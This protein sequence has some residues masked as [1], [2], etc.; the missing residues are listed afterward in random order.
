MVVQNRER[1]VFDQRLLEYTLLERSVCSD[2]AEA[3][4]M[5]LLLLMSVN[6]GTRF[7]W[8]EPHSSKYRRV[9]QLRL[10]AALSILPPTRQRA[11][12]KSQ[13]STIEQAT[14]RMT[15]N[16][17]PTM[18]FVSSLRV[19][20]PSNALQYRFNWQEQR[21]YKSISHVPAS[22]RA[23][24]E[25]CL[26]LHQMICDTFGILGCLCGDYLVLD[27]KEQLKTMPC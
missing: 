11:R 4:T 9:A 26:T 24:L 8:F 16:P 17:T 12:L 7:D 15:M 22:L 20:A 6:V 14:P 1:N 21:R 27:I 3:F 2:C 23:C 18:N 13:S 25:E 5:A 19:V 10:Q